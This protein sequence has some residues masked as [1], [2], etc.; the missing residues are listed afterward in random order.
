MHALQYKAS[1]TAFSFN[2]TLDMDRCKHPSIGP[3]KAATLPPEASHQKLQTPIHPKEFHVDLF[4][5]CWN[6][7]WERLTVLQKTPDQVAPAVWL[8][9]GG[10]LRSVGILI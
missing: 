10:T 4:V 2:W 1:Y 6:A 5:G 9:A 7:Q 8:M 3:P